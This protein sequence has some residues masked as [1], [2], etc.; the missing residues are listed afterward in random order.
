MSD[1]GELDAL[2]GTDSDDEPKVPE[3]VRPRK[4]EQAVPGL[5][6]AELQVEPAAAAAASR[7]DGSDADEGAGRR[8]R[9]PKPMG[10]PIS[11]EVRPSAFPA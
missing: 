5:E 1:D 11:M 6:T 2:F 9:S 4:E 10:A 8:S 3:T 7:G